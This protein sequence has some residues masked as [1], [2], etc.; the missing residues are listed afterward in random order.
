MNKILGIF[1]LLLVVGIIT[2]IVNPNFLL[3]FNLSNLLQR[4]ALFGIISIGVAFVIITG[5]I[6]LSIGSVISLTGCILSILLSASYSKPISEF[7]VLETS[8]DQRTVRL[9]QS[10]DA[11]ALQVGDRLLHKPR[12]SA[13]KRLNALSITTQQKSLVVTLQEEPAGL[14]PGDTV[15]VSQIQRLSRSVPLAV[16][17]V[18]LISAGIGL[19]HGLLITKLKL[20]P[21]V[22]TL[23][24]LLI[25]R[26]AARWLTADRSQGFGDEIYDG[27]RYL[28]KGQPISIPLPLTKWVSE[29]NWSRYQ[30]DW[31]TN[32]QKLDAS[33]AP[34]PLEMIDWIPVPMAAIILLGIA[35]VAIVFLN[36]SIWGRYLFALGRNEDAAR[37]SGI[38]TDRMIILAY[39]ICSLMAGVA[40]VLF[41]LDLNSFLPSG[42]ANFYELYAIA[43][44]VLGGCSLRGGEGSIIGVIIGAA[45]MRLLSNSI[46]LIGIQDQ[47]EFA[48]IGMVILTGVIA[49]ELVKRYAGRRRIRQEAVAAE[50]PPQ[51]E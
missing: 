43:A 15:K 19:I 48:V 42:H 41:A 27:L 12:G 50:S 45:L 22:V 37:F 32:K 49:D 47:L 16:V 25:Y 39:V 29:G 21:F 51:N 3:A 1:L 10:P 5:G 24:G 2:T 38:R 36:F 31:D 28:T 33:G 14:R 26:G 20:Q 7:R 40:G 13:Q 30:W 11:V 44:A 17:I 8:I 9:E 23:C 6:D 4:T 34:I 35:V 18:L 46:K